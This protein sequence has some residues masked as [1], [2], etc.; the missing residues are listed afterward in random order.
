V[1]FCACDNFDARVEVTEKIWRPRRDLNPCYRR[2]SLLANHNCMTLLA[3]EPFGKDL[4]RRNEQANGY[5]MGTRK[6]TREWIDSPSSQR[7][8][9]MR[10][11]E[12]FKAV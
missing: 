9:P 3:Q 1:P 8:I 5:P 6:T 12:T 2:E 4:V 11:E 10:L 7:G